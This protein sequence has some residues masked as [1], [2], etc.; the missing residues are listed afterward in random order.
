MEMNEHWEIDNKRNE[1]STAVRAVGHGYPEQKALLLTRKKQQTLSLHETDKGNRTWEADKSE[2]GALKNVTTTSYLNQ[3]GDSRTHN[4]VYSQRT[5][6]Q[7]EMKI[8]TFWTPHR[9]S[10]RSPADWPPRKRPGE[11]SASGSST[12]PHAEKSKWRLSATATRHDEA[13]EWTADGRMPFSPE[14]P[15]S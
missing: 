7:R 13:S 5:R 6:W 8:P 15:S 9:T 10:Q 1:E 3:T 14:T 2:H 11:A 4:K 12:P